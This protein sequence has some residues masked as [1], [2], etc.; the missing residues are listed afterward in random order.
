[1]DNVDEGYEIPSVLYKRDETY[2]Q[3]LEVDNDDGVLPKRYLLN[4]RSPLGDFDISDGPYNQ[5]A[6]G[7]LNANPRRPGN[8]TCLSPSGYRVVML[9]YTKNRSIER[10]GTLTSIVPLLPW[11]CISSKAASWV[12]AMHDISKQTFGVLLYSGRKGLAS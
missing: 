11:R 3:P 4:V 12:F 10:M 7:Q 8:P 1:L 5:W 6:V 2:I 9:T